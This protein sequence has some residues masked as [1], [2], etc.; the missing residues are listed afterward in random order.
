MPTATGERQTLQRMKVG[1]VAD[2][3]ERW[4]SWDAA[5]PVIAANAA[6]F[7]SEVIVGLCVIIVTDVD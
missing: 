4:E 3:S 5:L 2:R 7:S 6:A 1:T